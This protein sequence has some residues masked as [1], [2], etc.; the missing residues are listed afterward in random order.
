MQVAALISTNVQDSW[1]KLYADG[2]RPTWM[3]KKFG[4]EYK[5]FAA[6]AKPQD[7][8]PRDKWQTLEK[9]GKN[10]PP[11]FSFTTSPGYLAAA[12]MKLEQVSWRIDARHAFFVLTSDVHRSLARIS[13]CGR[14]KSLFFPRT[15]SPP[16]LPIWPRCSSSSLVPT[17][18]P[19]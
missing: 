13:R 9:I 3:S 2:W 1:T 6:W 5:V 15:I 16:S 7:G 10:R 14:T 12:Y 17:E 18:P 4:R 19:S 11:Q 8:V